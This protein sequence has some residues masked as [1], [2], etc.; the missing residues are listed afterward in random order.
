MQSDNVKIVVNSSRYVTIKFES[1]LTLSEAYN[2]IMKELGSNF[3]DPRYK[4]YFIHNDK[5][6]GRIKFGPRN[7]LPFNKKVSEIINE[8]EIIMKREL[9]ITLDDGITTKIFTLDSE[10]ND[11]LIRIRK[12]LNNNEIVKTQNFKFLKDSQQGEDLEM[13]QEESEMTIRL[14]EVIKSSDVIRI[15]LNEF[16]SGSSTKPFFNEEIPCDLTS[17]NEEILYKSHALESSPNV[18]EK[19]EY[20][21]RNFD[22]CKLDYG[23]VFAREGVKL[24]NYRSFNFIQSIEFS[25]LENQSKFIAKISVYERINDF[26]YAKNQ[27]DLTSEENLSSEW[28]ALLN[29][30]QNSISQCHPLFDNKQ[31][32]DNSGNIYFTI[33]NERVELHLR[34]ELIKPSIE[35]RSAVNK[36]IEGKDPY[37]KLMN[38]F[39]TFGN[40]FAQRVILGIKLFKYV[41]KD[42]EY[43]DRIK[44]DS[45][46]WETLN[47][48]KEKSI[49]L[50]NMLIYLDKNDDDYFLTP[51]DERIELDKLYEWIES[52]YKANVELQIISYGDLV[53][54]YEIFEEPIR[55]K[56]KS[57]LGIYDYKYSLSEKIYL[58]HLQLP[59]VKQ[60]I[61]MSGNEQIN[62]SIT[63][64]R[65]KFKNHLKND[66]YQL[67]GSITTIFGE[68][69]KEKTIKFKLANIFGFS[70]LIKNVPGKESTYSGKIN[71]NWMLIGNPEDIEKSFEI[72]NKKNFE[73][74]HK[75]FIIVK[76]DSQNI[77][78]NKEVYLRTFLPALPRNAVFAYTFEYP[79][80]YNET[81]LLASIK[82]VDE[83][84]IQLNIQEFPGDSK[85]NDENN[86][87]KEKTS[88]E[89]LKFKMHWCI[90][91]TT[92]RNITIGQFLSNECEDLSKKIK[93]LKR[94]PS[95]KETTKK[96]P[97]RTPVPKSLMFNYGICKSCK[98]PFTG[99]DW[100][101]KCQ[102]NYFRNKDW[103]SRNDTIDKFIQNIQLCAQ[104]SIQIIE[105]VEYKDLYNIRFIKENINKNDNNVYSALWLNVSKVPTIDF[106]LDSKGL[107]PKVSPDFRLDSKE[108]ISKISSGER[109]K[110]T[111]D[112]VPKYRELISNCWESDP[113]KRPKAEEI[114]KQIKGWREESL[115]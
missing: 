14:E 88:P 9:S 90:Y 96:G 59:D 107:V 34:K 5:E 111:E 25:T 56:I 113:L 62:G 82:S 58:D 50:K 45:I 83:K 51:K 99:I 38:V 81:L 108:F 4:F 24:G 1:D 32:S 67:Y 41:N 6:I 26:F 13:V 27:L 8:G 2:Q 98:E 95:G 15:S 64:H 72:E 35:F 28:H 68:P 74:L 7:K 94:R 70:V 105:W 11:T 85:L 36:A 22:A 57:I 12:E 104:N 66:N 43:C 80:S 77:E 84:G 47:D 61:L 23:L 10:L 63:Y 91:L 101:N 73:S 97:K 19:K 65:I 21:K 29:D 46:E 52:C 110:F 44:E 49:T 75:N 37:S 53:A 55:N 16:T 60:K 112:I 69:I 93:L 48:F 115:K 79:S 76:V 86:D 103:T 78:P 87:D 71:I 20:F 92:I 30:E 114:Y 31:F 54:I 89:E 3:N 42:N 106:K 109:P 17:D 39:T 33:I 40:F 18:N 102:A 100:C